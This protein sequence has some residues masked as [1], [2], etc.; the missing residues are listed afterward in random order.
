MIYKLIFLKKFFFFKGCVN[1]KYLSKEEGV[2]L[3]VSYGDSVLHSHTVTNKSKK[4]T[5]IPMLS[6]FAEI[7]ARFSDLKEEGDGMVGCLN[8]E[9]TFL[10]EVTGQYPVGCFR[11]NPN[12]MVLDNSILTSKENEDDE[13][14][15]EST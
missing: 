1:M 3:N 2:L 5:C 11:M 7:C 8:F 4:G 13:K 12:A 15:E 9:P 6:Y 10:G 14:S